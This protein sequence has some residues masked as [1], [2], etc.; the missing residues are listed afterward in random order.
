MA[1]QA[2]LLSPVCW[3]VEASLDPPA[4]ASLKAQRGRAEQPA[5]A[6]AAQTPAYPSGGVPTTGRPHPPPQTHCFNLGICITRVR[7]PLRLHLDSAGC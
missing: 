4:A 1:L 2:M 6:R 5:M 3:D 7:R